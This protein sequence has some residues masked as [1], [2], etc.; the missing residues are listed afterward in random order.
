MP[1]SSGDE[2]RLK[3]SPVIKFEANVYKIAWCVAGFSC[4]PCFFEV[5]T[6]LNKLHNPLLLVT[7]LF[8]NSS[9]ENQ[10]FNLMSIHTD[11]FFIEVH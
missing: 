11:Y 9:F 8:I 4:V 6:V 7:Y 1:I 5:I 3:F 2:I 10:F